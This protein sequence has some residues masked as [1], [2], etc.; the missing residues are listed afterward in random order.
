MT[1]FRLGVAFL[2]IALLILIGFAALKLSPAISGT[3]EATRSTNAP[4]T[5]GRARNLHLIELSQ[6]YVAPDKA[7]PSI[8]LKTGD[9]MA[10]VQFLNDELQKNGTK[11]RVRS[12]DGLEAETYDVS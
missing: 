12:V 6:R 8:A 11:W 2:G 5:V 7:T 9:A 4:R 1:F 3:T 10:P